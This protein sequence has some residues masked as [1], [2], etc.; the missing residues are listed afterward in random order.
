MFTNQINYSIRNGLLINTITDHLPIFALCNCEIENKK[1]DPVKYVRNFK[2]ENL[3]L[4][5]ESLSQEIWNDMLQSDDVNVACINFIETF[6]KLY[7]RHCHVKKAHP[8]VIAK[9][10]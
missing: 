9:K 7:N 8:K 2:N 10:P 3:S 4:L 6:S 5:I 1:S